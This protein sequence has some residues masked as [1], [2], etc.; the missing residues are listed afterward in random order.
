MAP[1]SY[2]RIDVNITRPANA[3]GRHNNRFRRLSVTRLPRRHRLSDGG[4]EARRH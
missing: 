4:S 2:V 3:I 1:S